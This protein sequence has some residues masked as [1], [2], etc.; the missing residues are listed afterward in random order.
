MAGSRK[1]FRY[2]TAG[3]DVYAL[4]M[5]ES[6]GEHVGNDDLTGFGSTL[7]SL[8]PNIRPRFCVYRSSDGRY[9]R[10]IPVSSPTTGIDDLPATLSI[11]PEG[12]GTAVVLNLSYFQG[13]RITRIPTGADTGLNDG[14]D[15]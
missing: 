14:D 15:T 8:P 9:S 6:N 4:N 1:W 2:T 7:V 12:G 11:T 10:R 13:E 3:G 5:D